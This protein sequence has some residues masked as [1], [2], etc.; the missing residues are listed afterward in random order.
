MGF[1][2]TLFLKDEL[3]RDLPSFEGVGG[4]E[5]PKQYQCLKQKNARSVPQ[6]GAAVGK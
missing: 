2:G 4:G 3:L 5:F 1:S 6:I